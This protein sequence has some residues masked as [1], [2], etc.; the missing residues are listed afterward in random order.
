MTDTKLPLG[1]LTVMVGPNAAGKS[2]VLHALE[3]LG[4]VARQG[5]EPA[6]DERGGFDGTGLPG[7]RRPVS[8]IPVGV[9][10]IWSEFSSE[11]EPDRFELSVSCRKRPDSP[12]RGRRVFFRQERFTQ[13][14]AAGTTTSVGL[15]SDRLTASHS[16]WSDRVERIASGLHHPMGLP[17]SDPSTAAIGRVDSPPHRQ[18]RVFDPD[19]RAARKPWG[20]ANWATATSRTTPPTSPASS[21]A[22]RTTE[23]PGREIRSH[24]S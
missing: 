12:G 14:P 13:H 7:G 20:S 16:P 15:A 1:P 9:Q 19:V 24:R 2:N 22:S 17:A 3:F 21:R 11:E 6:L 10:G 5:I 8:R 18:I 4:D 23:M